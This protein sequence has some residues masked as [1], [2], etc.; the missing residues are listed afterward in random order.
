MVF[1]PVSSRY[2]LDVELPRL[3]NKDNQQRNL[4]YGFAR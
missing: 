1:C 3:A 4:P 2:S